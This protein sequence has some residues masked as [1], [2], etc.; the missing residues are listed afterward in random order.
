MIG[1]FCNVLVFRMKNSMSVVKPASHCFACKKKIIWRD[2]IP[3]ISFLILRGEC[4]NCKAKI[5]WQYPMVEFLVG[6]TWGL[7]G[8]LYYFNFF[9]N[10]F[11]AITWSLIF[12]ALWVIF[13]YD[14]KYMEI[15]M[16]LVWFSLVLIIAINFFTD[17]INL[18]DCSIFFEST[19]FINGLSGLVAFIFFFGL[20]FISNEEWMGYGDSFLALLI[21][22]ALGPV[23]SF[24]AI[25]VAFCVGSI[26]SI[27]IVILG[28]AD[29]KSQVP[30]GPFLIFGFMLM[31]FV[32]FLFPD[33]L[34]LFV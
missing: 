23:A 18:I 15:P 29:L 9:E 10:F 4:R 8:Y 24:L 26:F 22:L 16:N 28:K 32:K 31:F 19:I 25:L 12:S 20:S 3:I 14:W 30:F 13:I 34:N 6:I 1:S 33:L 17:K 27:T 2:N 5:S 7:I 11:I 21:G